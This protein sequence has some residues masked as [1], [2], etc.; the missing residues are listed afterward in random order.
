MATKLTK[1][2]CDKAEAPDSGYRFI[3]DEELPG[4]GLRVTANGAKAFI[5]QYRNRGGQTKRQTIGKYGGGLTAHEAR[6]IASGK[7]VEVL[8]GGDPARDRA[9]AAKARTVRQL[10]SVFLEQHGPKRAANTV[11]NYRMIFEH[12]VLPALGGRLVQEV[13]WNDV[14]QLHGRM[15]ETTPIRRIGC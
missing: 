8:Q 5:F 1:T 13:D 2:V 14:H 9:E 11:R 7:R 3:W 4:F 10:A 15:G 12:H 6:K